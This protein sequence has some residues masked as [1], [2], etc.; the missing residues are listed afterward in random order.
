MNN[1]LSI[2]AFAFVV[3]F[4]LYIFGTSI[5]RANPSSIIESKSASATTT[6]TFMTPGN[7]TTTRVIDLQAD[8]AP[9]D[10]AALLIRFNSS[11]TASVLKW[12]YEFAQNPANQYGVPVD[13]VATPGQCD[14]F[15][16]SVSATVDDTASTTV[17]VGAFKEY[18]WQFASSTPGGV[19]APQDNG[20]KMVI[21]PTPT[22]YIRVVF[23]LA[24][25]I[26][27]GNG[28]VW[29][30]LAYKRENR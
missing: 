14:W 21:L 18:S 20:L 15:S 2:S 27:M 29:S 26:G 13:C 11:S 16:E 1:K 30:D 19:T 8:N 22:R 6:L 25:G 3:L 4:M 12:R 5:V 24:P 10:T 28:A 7:A 17:E 9:A 23:Y